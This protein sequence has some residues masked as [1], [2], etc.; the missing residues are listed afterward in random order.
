MTKTKD[1]KKICFIIMPISDQEGYDKGHFKRVYEHIIKPACESAGFKPIRADDEV[2]TNYIVIDIIKK[3]IESD[4]VLCDLSSKNANVF[5]ELGIRQ[6]FNKKAVLIKDIKTGRV[7]DIQGLRAID[8]D[9]S[10]RIDSVVKNIQEI[11]NTLKETYEYDGDDINSLIQL[12]SIQPAK[13]SDSFELSNESSIILK[14][15]DEIQSRIGNL[16]KFD[17]KSTSTPYNAKEYIIDGIKFVLDWFVDLEDKALGKIIKIETDKIVLR[18]NKNQ[19]VVINKDNPDFKN[20]RCL[21]F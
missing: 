15:I 2:K 11:S 4:M 21:P 13:L 14:A 16:E 20:L 1:E 6:A 19:I 3:I 5:Y 12:L 7:F 17:S 9:E 8:Y 18:N 10:L